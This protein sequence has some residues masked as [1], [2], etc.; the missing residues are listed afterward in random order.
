MNTL[1]II[2]NPQVSPP[3]TGLALTPFSPGQP[4]K[5][6]GAGSCEDPALALYHGRLF[7]RRSLN[8][9]SGRALAGQTA[10]PVSFR[11]VTHLGV[12]TTVLTLFR[13][14]FDG[15]HHELRQLRAGRISI[16]AIQTRIRCLTTQGRQLLPR[17]QRRLHFL[18]KLL[19]SHPGKLLRWPKLCPGADHLLQF[20]S[21]LFRTFCAHITCLCSV[22]L[23]VNIL[24]GDMP[25]RN[26]LPPATNPINLS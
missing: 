19:D 15:V 26:S 10:S 7:N 22:A 9:R 24:P 20:S 12:E 11:R 16:V 2:F 5:K 13:V 4:R 6:K 17:I 3:R 23:F 14:A 18:V 1:N 21:N 8:R 25:W